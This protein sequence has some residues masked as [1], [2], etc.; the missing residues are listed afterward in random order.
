MVT[1]LFLPLGVRKRVT[2]TISGKGKGSPITIPPGEGKGSPFSIRKRFAKCS[3]R[4]ADAHVVCVDVICS[5]VDLVLLSTSP[6]V[7]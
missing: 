3:E 1:T 2:N 7:C 4:V 6:K 5:V